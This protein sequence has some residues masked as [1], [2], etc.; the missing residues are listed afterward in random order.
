M[1][2]ALARRLLFLLPAETAHAAALTAIDAARATGLLARLVPAPPAD[3]RTVMGLRFANPVGLAAGLDKN[4]DHVDALGELG[5]GFV[6]V[7]TV[8]PRAQPGNPR[9][10]LFR[11]PAEGALIN[12][13]GFNNKGVNHAVARLERRRFDGIVG[14]NI[15]KNRDTPLERA[16]D[17]YR[18]CLKRVHPVADY[19][20]VNVSSPNTPGLRSLQSGSALDRLLGGLA[21]V[22]ARLEACSNRRVPLLVKIAPDIDARG[23]ET[24]AT[25]LRRHGFDGAIATNTTADH[26]AVAG[27]RYADE[28]GGLSVA[29]VFERSTEVLRQLAAAL[30]GTL[31]VIGV[32]GIDSGADAAAKRTAGAELVQLYTGL[33][34]RGPALV[35]EAAEALR[36]HGAQED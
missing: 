10:R 3:P 21:E 35:R 15:G 11:I 33:I 9:P 23:I 22:R 32:G 14:V 5:F 30:D 17:D 13:M 36:K 1:T 27:H 28:E 4:A 18:L 19:V 2:Y 26:A 8:T 7:G 6:E 31:P 20:T 24:M 34:Y 25:G 12:R 29:P 16:F